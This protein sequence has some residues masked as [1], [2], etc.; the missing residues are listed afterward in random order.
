MDTLSKEDARLF[1]RL[2]NSLLYHTNK[3][4]SVIKNATNQ[5]EFMKRN[6]S[7]IVPLWERIFSQKCE[8]IDHYTLD[9]PDRFTDEEISIISGWKDYRKG[10][11]FIIKYVKDHALLFDPKTQSVYGVKGITDSFKE[12]FGGYAPLIIRINLIPFKGSIIYEGVFSPF[13]IHMGRNMKT[14]LKRESEEAII[15]KGIITS[16]GKAEKK[17]ADDES[18]LKFYMKSYENKMRYANEIERLKKSSATLEALYYREE[19]RDRA[20]YQKREL[21]EMGMKGHFAILNGA[22]VA[23]GRTENE[24]RENL[25]RMVQKERLNWVY[26]FKL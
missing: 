4:I 1:H 16:F 25:E 22:I 8:L 19:G 5:A 24:M 12:K 26:V 9:N 17:G 6:I 2:M 3:E 21:K 20:R 10:E 18:M 7:E 13:N 15:K 11:F 14:G 23:S